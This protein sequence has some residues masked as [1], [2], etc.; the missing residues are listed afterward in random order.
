MMI[1][2]LKARFSAAWAAFK[3]HPEEEM[4]EYYRRR[5]KELNKEMKVGRSPLIISPTSASTYN[6]FRDSG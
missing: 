3:K 5:T 4:D 2:I 1:K 6:V